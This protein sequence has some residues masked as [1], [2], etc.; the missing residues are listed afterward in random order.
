MKKA[1]KVIS[2]K[3]L[4]ANIPL[5]STLTAYLTL[6]KFNAPEW[7]WGV[8]AFVFIGGWITAIY[9][10]ISDDDIDLLKDK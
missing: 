5:W 4:P 6:D 10:I 2:R 7:L 9:R 8:I 3:N 1:N